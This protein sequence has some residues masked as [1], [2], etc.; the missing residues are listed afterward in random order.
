M[1]GAIQYCDGSDDME[2]GALPPSYDTRAEWPACVPEVVNSGNCSASYAVASANSLSARFCLQDGD[3]YGELRLSAQQI[4]SCDKKSRGCRGGGVDFVWSYMERRGL[5]PAS[6]L[7]FAGEAGA[8]CATECKEEQ[9]LKPI[10]HC[11]MAGEKAIKKEIQRNGPVVAP[12]LLTEEFLVY[13]GGVFDHTGSSAPVL[14]SDGKTELVHAVLVLGW[15]KDQGRKYWIVQNSWGDKW[16]EEG[17]GRVR[18][19][20]SA[21][22]NEGYVMVGHPETSEAKEKAAQAKIDA[23]KRKEEAKKERQARDERIKKRQAEEKARKKEARA[24]GEAVEAEDGK[25]LD[26]IDGEDVDL[27]AEDGKEEEVEI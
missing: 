25:P 8:K 17:F 7:S 9:K 18:A 13:S 14:G 5:Y 1:P 10:S 2:S 11:V 15:G 26:D 6:C 16:G 3:K 22:L 19:G 24:R 20:G 23:E 27:D 12:M 4:L 21:V